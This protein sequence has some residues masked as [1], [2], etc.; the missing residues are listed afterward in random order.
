MRP[1]NSKRYSA[2]RAAASSIRLG[3]RGMKGFA[4]IGLALLLVSCDGRVPRLRLVAGALPVDR[5][6]AGALAELLTADTAVAVDLLPSP[7]EGSAA[8]D[9]IDRGAADL[10]LVANNVAFRPTVRTVLPVYSSVLHIAYRRGLD[11]SDGQTLLRGATVFAGTP[12]SPTRAMLERILPRL[13]LTPAE[14]TFANNLDSGPDVVVVF[15]PISPDRIDRLSD[16]E[17]FSLGTPLEIGRGGA[18]D[19]VS[20]M[21][22]QL[23]PFIIPQGVYG[24]KTLQP[25][26]TVAVDTVLVGSERL[27]AA[28]VYDLVE[29]LLAL[30]NALAA[31]RP[32]WF[33]AL[34]DD[35]DQAS[36]TFAA[37]AGTRAFQRRNAP[38]VYERFA[39]VVEAVLTAFV[40]VGSAM[41][42]L[43]RFARVRRKNRIDRFY[44]QVLDVRQRLMSES[45]SEEQRA[46][47]DQRL[48]LLENEAFDLLM[49]ERLAADESFSIFLSL[50]GEARRELASHRG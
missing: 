19:A 15:A 39:G 31:E 49:A 37:H 45:L 5:D 22:P 8:L 40:A 30:R 13:G 48:R 27:Q 1:Q 11:A 3:S 2:A 14:L 29:R 50:L 24:K 4:L 43:F 21:F 17:L 35:F 44:R 10:A 34:S 9:A 33:R 32:G 25:I 47:L 36:L 28:T 38:T 42:A 26:V 12:G 23:R 6:V 16:Y 7:L 41:L 20:L 18:V 46:G